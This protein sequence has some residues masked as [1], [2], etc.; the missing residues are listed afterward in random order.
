MCFVSKDFS[1]DLKKS[2]AYQKS[3]EMPDGKIINLSEE[4]FHTPEYM[5][6]PEGINYKEDVPPLQNMIVEAINECNEVQRDDL[7]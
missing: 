2:Y 6:D 1:E 7:Y 3:Y 4:R 5:L